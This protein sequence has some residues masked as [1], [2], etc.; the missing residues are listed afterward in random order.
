[1][2][3]LIPHTQASLIKNTVQ[4]GSHT[5]VENGIIVLKKAIKQKKAV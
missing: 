1:M 2:I 5:E 3:L 4:R